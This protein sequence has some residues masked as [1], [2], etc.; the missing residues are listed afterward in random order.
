[1]EVSHFFIF[2]ILTIIVIICGDIELNPGSKKNKSLC[3]WNLNSIIYI[4]FPSYLFLRPI[5][6]H[7]IICFSE[8]YLESSFTY[9]V[10]RLRLSGNKIVRAENL[11]DNKR[12]G[13]DIYSTVTL[14]ICL[15]LLTV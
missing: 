11:N 10:V 14:G 4:I 3:H 9:D 6:L 13:V 8:T 15:D 1:M 2:C 12:G 7:N 5:A